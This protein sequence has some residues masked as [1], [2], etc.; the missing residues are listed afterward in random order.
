MDQGPIGP[1]HGDHVIRTLIAV[2]V[3]VDGVSGAPGRDGLCG[4]GPPM[5][6]LG[7]LPGTRFAR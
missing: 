3:W 7:P 4:T 5:S 6:P 1:Q 2:G